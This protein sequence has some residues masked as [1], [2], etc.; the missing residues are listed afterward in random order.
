MGFEE[1]VNDQNGNPL[2]VTVLIIDINT[3]EIVYNSTEDHHNTTVSPGTYHVVII[4]PGD[5]SSIT[6]ITFWYVNIT[7]SINQLVDLSNIFDIRY[8][9]PNVIYNNVFAANLVLTAPYSYSTLYFVASAPS[10]YKCRVF[11]FEDQICY[12]QWIKV[13][14]DLVVGQVYSIN[15]TRGDPA[16]GEG[17]DKLVLTTI[18]VNGNMTDWAAVLDNSNN[19][20][21]DG[22]SGIDDPDNP[23]T[24]SRDL[25]KFA[26]TWDSNNFYTY[27]RRVYG[28][29]SAVTLLVY[30][31]YGQDGYMNSSDKVL[32]IVWRGG[33]KK[34]RHESVRHGH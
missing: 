6:N 12:G 16:F 5:Y 3:G 25:T 20:I 8:L 34:L 18:T 9:D 23:T 33:S 29:P 21:T 19:I 7:T 24:V 17:T 4:P 22:V 13:L 31:D 1:D 15:L 11:D 30:L 2:N 14:D 26:F 10:L 32:R 27:F 28:T